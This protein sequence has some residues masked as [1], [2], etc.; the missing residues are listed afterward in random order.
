MKVWI[1]LAIV[2]MFFI[3]SY[4]IGEA[5]NTIVVR[6]GDQAITEQQF[7]LLHQIISQQSGQVVAKEGVLE[8]LVNTMLLAQEA[9]K[10]KL[11]EM[12]DIKQA[13]M[14]Q[15]SGLLASTLLLKL[16]QDLQPSA[17]EIQQA[18][19][20]L[21][22]E[23]Y[24]LGYILVNDKTLA[25]KIITRLTNKENFTALAKQF[26][27][28]S[29]RDKGGAIDWS[30]DW[31]TSDTLI[32]VIASLKAGQHTQEPIKG[33]Q[34]WQILQLKQ[35]RTIN[36]ATVEALRQQMQAQ[37][38]DEKINHYVEGLKD[39]TEVVYP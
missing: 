17:Q 13:L 37:L 16:R 21:P 9:E 15:R 4:S 3:S 5:K 1:L 2:G 22:T 28:D 19:Q 39:K 18:Y 14:Q 32:P 26:S 11:H 30:N 38:I 23:E 8:E 20:D 36:P 29:S 34:G 35:R 33:Q 25:R 6:V 10:Q 27:I 7:Q 24:Q 12:P 31:L